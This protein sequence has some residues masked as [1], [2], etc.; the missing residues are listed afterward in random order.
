MCVS[1]YI[2]FCFLLG[3]TRLFCQPSRARSLICS[4]VSVKLWQLASSFHDAQ[5]IAGTLLGA[6]QRGRTGQAEEFVLVFA[7]ILFKYT[8]L[9]LVNSLDS[10][11][12]FDKVPPPWKD[13]R[14]AK[15]RSLLHVQCCCLGAGWP[16][17]VVEPEQL[18]AH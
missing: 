10:N 13:R 1:T 12:D 15:R 16:W 7:I 3:S 6:L 5:A 14:G 17:Q 11:N 9:Q 8:L 18:A 2:G 4:V